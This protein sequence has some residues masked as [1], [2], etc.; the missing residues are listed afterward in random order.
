M[1][2]SGVTA[3]RVGTSIPTPTKVESPN[4][5]GWWLAAAI[6]FSAISE[7]AGF[8]VAPKS[9]TVWRANFYRCGGRTDPQYACWNHIDN[10]QPDF[11]RPEFFGNLT[12][13]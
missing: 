2:P 8:K 1:A 12:F 9:G 10:P 13:E 11:H 4:D 5:D 7:L 6:P 3:R